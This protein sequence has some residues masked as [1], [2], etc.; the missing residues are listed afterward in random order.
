[1]TTSV[2]RRIANDSLQFDVALQ[3]LDQIGIPANLHQQVVKHII[4]VAAPADGLDVNAQ[5]CCPEKPFVN[6]MSTPEILQFM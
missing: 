5:I 6:S 2:P 3:V 1:L 4:A